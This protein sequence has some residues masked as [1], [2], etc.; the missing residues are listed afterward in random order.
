MKELKEWLVSNYP[1][2][3]EEINNITRI[4]EVR[5]FILDNDNKRE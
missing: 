5:N 2:K 3:E 4:E 1:D